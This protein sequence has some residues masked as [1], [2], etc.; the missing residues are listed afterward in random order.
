MATSSRDRV[1]WLC[2]VPSA[3]AAELSIAR[4]VRSV[5]PPGIPEIPE[6]ASELRCSIPPGQ[7]GVGGFAAS[8]QRARASGAQPEAGWRGL[9]PRRD[10][11]VGVSA[12]GGGLDLEA[13]GGQIVGG[14]Y[15]AAR[16]VLVGAE[17]AL[18]ALGGGLLGLAHLALALQ[19]GH[20]ALLGHN[21]S[22]NGGVSYNAPRAVPRPDAPAG[23][24]S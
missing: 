16:G 15:L 6:K 4:M 1:A 18:L 22:P 3:R 24:E 10:R 11:L 2:G 21:G 17:L 5:G 9:R 12:P 20:A 7:G 8:A 19:D 13:V 23:G 14:G